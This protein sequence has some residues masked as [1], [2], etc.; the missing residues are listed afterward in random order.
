ML[1]QNVV[2]LANRKARRIAGKK[3]PRRIGYTDAAAT[4][5]GQ[6]QAAE[7]AEGA[8]IAESVAA[9]LTQRTRLH[10]S[11]NVIVPIS[12]ETLILAAA[13][14][15]GEPESQLRNVNNGT[16]CQVDLLTYDPWFREVNFFEV[17]RGTAPIGANHRRVRLLEHV[18]LAITG[19]AFV[20]ESLGE[21]VHDVSTRVISYYGRSGFDSAITITAAELDTVFGTT[22]RA[23]VDAH[24]AF[25]RYRLDCRIPGLTGSVYPPLA[26]H[27]TQPRPA[28]PGEPAAAAL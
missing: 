2:A 16:R 6:L 14:N 18:A 13:A 8:V 4:L 23:E 9:A 28:D 5:A 17:K 3:A 20:E 19:A 10:V 11:Q 27:A 22:V 15:G 21:P 1:D 7:N 24:L 25:F 12:R 26:V